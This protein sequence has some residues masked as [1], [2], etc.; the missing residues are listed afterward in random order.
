MSELTVKLSMTEDVSEKM[1][2][3]SSASSKANSDLQKVG[4]TIDNAFKSSSAADFAKQAGSAAENLAEEFEQLG[5]SVS[6]VFDDVSQG[7]AG[8]LG[9]D[10]SEGIGKAAESTEDLSEA[11]RELGEGLE[12]AARPAEDL[13]KGLSG[14][15]DNSDGLGEV[16]KEAEDAGESLEKMGKSTIDLGSALKTLFAIALGAKALGEIK[17]FAADSISLGRDFTSMMS[18]VQAISGA[19]G[20][21]IAMLEETARSYGATTVFSASEAA[22][23]LKYMSLAGWDAN[24][25]AAALGGVLDL[26]AASGMGLGQASD[27]VT[28]YLS[29][30]GMQASESAY[31]ADMLAY[32]Q[33][34]S[35]TSVTQLG[36]AY[37]NTAANMNAAGQDVETTTSLLEAMANQGYK[38]SEA[39]TALTAIMRDITNSMENGAIKIGDTSI[40]VSDAEGNFRDLTDVLSDVE[41]AT[42]GMGDAERAAALGAT[43]TADSTKGLNLIL[44]EGMDAISGYE[45]ELRRAGGTATEMAGVMNDN[46]SGDM[47]NMN[48][49]FE[50]LKLK[51]YDGMEAPLRSGVQYI[52]SE[53]IPALSEWVPEA[54]SSLMSG[55][56]KLGSSLKPLFETV[57]KNPKA[58]GTAITSIAAGF[59][60]MKAVNIASDLSK[61]LAG[62]TSFTG[63]LDKLGLSMLSNPWA[64]GAAAVAAAVTAIGFAVNEYNNM[65]IN[66]SLTAHFG[67]VELSDD[68]I[69]DFATRIIDA[70]WVVN[71]NT[72]LG[73]FDNAEQ[74]QKEAEEALAANDALEWKAR[75]GIS[76]TKDEQSTYMQNIADFKSEMETALQEQTLAAEMSIATFDIKMQDGTSLSDKI[77]EW[78]NKDLQDMS[79]LSSGLTKLVQT[80][81]EDGIIDVDEQAAIDQLQQKISNI[82]SGWK[83]AEAQAEFD[84]LTQKYGRLSG[85]DLEEGTF[86]SLATELGE[87]R[88]LAA[89]ALYE[90]EKQVYATLN[91]LNQTNEEGIQRITDSDLAFYKEQV[92]Q[93]SRNAE[94]AMLLKSVNF[95]KNTM[96]D[97]YGDL[98][99]S[100][101]QNIQTGAQTSVDQLSQLYEQYQNG[102]A[103]MESL[104]MNMENSVLN[105]SAGDGRGFFGWITDKDQAAIADIYEVMKPDMTALQ[106]VISEYKEVGQAVPREIM[107]QFNEA[108]LIG[109][110][111]GDMDAAWY[112]YAQQMVESGNEQM[113][114]AIK[115]GE[116]AAPQELRDAL[117]LATMEVTDDP[118]TIEGL[119]AELD[120]VEVNQDHVNELIQAALGDLG[121]V[122]GEVDGNIK[123]K[124][125]KGDCLSQIGEAL[126]VDWHEIAAYNGIEEPYT[127]YP[128]ME[129]L[130]PK[131]DVSIDT[132]GA[133]E[134]AAEAKEEAERE[135]EAAT[136]EPIETDQQVDITLTD[137]DTKSELST[138]VAEDPEPIEQERTVNTTY[139][140]GDTTT[141]L[142]TPELADPEPVKQ[143]VP[144]TITFEVA[145]LDDSE[146]ASA[147]ST[148]LAQ[149]EAVPVT[150]PA[151][152]TF[153]MAKSDTTAAMTAAQTALK[154]A[155]ATP[156]PA[157]G[158]TD[159]T[160]TK[161]SDNISSVYSQVGSELQNAFSSGYSVSTS[162]SIH[163]N[164]SIA[165]P[166]A[167][168]GFSGF[169]A[170]S[171]TVTAY[172]HAMGGIFTE[173][174]VGVI[175]EAGYPESII[176]IDGSQN[177][178]N[179]W[180]ETGRMLG[181]IDAPVN[182]PPSSLGGAKTAGVTVTAGGEN[183]KSID[184]NINGTGSL[185]ISSGMS[186]EN[187][188]SIIYE[189]LKD[190]LMKIV[191]QE[192][193]E[194][195]DGVY[196]Y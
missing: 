81:L 140:Q 156:L 54:F 61:T 16:G 114:S 132:T 67:N 19:T 5:E 183:R 18:E 172:L 92:A 108:M 86:T 3:V 115:S 49:A 8:D 78:A 136:A 117:E 178:I 118:V 65:Q 44:N 157:D 4:K 162:A 170:G 7:M 192:I 93:A 138:P 131:E 31:F 90:N 179:L 37:K 21:E 137:G 72:A 184:L 66:E 2:K 74:A 194:E 12:G 151:D 142:T 107:S 77:T 39:G 186:K 95:E 89:E 75:V 94:T 23:A 84:M 82:M 10:L 70:E 38:G 196:E 99:T 9:A 22:E 96:E 43:F 64:A 161:A 102:T 73:H 48:S 52:T 13:G 1:S 45:E 55:L 35:N 69:T 59:T 88:Q 135:V 125:E 185:K 195:G 46:L 182:V 175:A 121:T 111:S 155:F 119:Q 173:P 47:A 103:T 30:F 129:I 41:N 127:I 133:G 11:A 191:E 15:G 123:V 146:L 150:V 34:N 104:F 177:A 145:S 24:Q 188:V 180:E 26:A 63:A 189:N 159:V 164:Y 109:A 181:T 68:M 56:Q 124:V 160:I 85:A 36:E 168:I 101:Y 171:T 120:N 110:A 130:I 79:Y 143:Q 60:A 176:P 149:S 187:I 126:G 144:T 25:Q 116:I 71:V 166:V 27:M 40:A 91:A 50:E 163:V 58:V 122:E 106:G 112:V 28:D 62:V 158:T 190:V 154:T 83:E 141:E 17:D 105:S 87:Q 51:V 113:V 147:I 42:N 134:A 76:L 167:S 6:S 139:K 165:N 33:A 80:A 97:A 53:V 174:H 57:M 32:A 20:S 193:L 148:K 153:E 152:V 169:G 128:D 29:A 14:I 98:L 100:N